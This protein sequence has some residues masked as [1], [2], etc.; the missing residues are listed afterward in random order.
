MLLCCPSVR[1]DDRVVSCSSLR[2]QIQALPV[3]TDDAFAAVVRALNY[4]KTMFP[5]LAHLPNNLVVKLMKS[6]LSEGNKNISPGLLSVLTEFLRALLYTLDEKYETVIKDTIGNFVAQMIMGATK[7]VNI[8]DRNSA[9]FFLHVLHVMYLL[10]AYGNDLRQAASPIGKTSQL[11]SELFH[12]TTDATN[13]VSTSLSN[14][15]C[16]AAASLAPTAELI[17]KMIDVNSYIAW[18]DIN[19]QESFFCY[20]FSIYDSTLSSSLQTFIRFSAFLYLHTLKEL[21]GKLAYK[22][23]DKTIPSTCL[24]NILQQM[25]L[26]PERDPDQ[27]L[28]LDDIVTRLSAGKICSSVPGDAESSPL[29]TQRRSKLFN[30]LLNWREPSELFRREEVALLVQDELE[31]VPV[32]TAEKLLE[33]YLTNQLNISLSWKVVSKITNIFLCTYIHM[34]IFVHLLIAVLYCTRTYVLKHILCFFPQNISPTQA[35]D[36]HLQAFSLAVFYTQP[37]G[38]IWDKIFRPL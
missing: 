18:N 17:G 7:L 2:S 9:Y 32:F 13:A 3:L 22:S 23:E 4:N 36:F 16:D 35:S 20:E 8:S 33:F 31:A 26:D 34:F 12:Q 1:S 10:I 30:M 14:T 15:L 38:G 11:L 21:S 25:A 28:S 29:D 37:P 6:S 19:I 27:E 24:L 5:L